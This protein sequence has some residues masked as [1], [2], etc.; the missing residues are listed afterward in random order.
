MTTTLE[1]V[2]D[3]Y[4][5]AEFMQDEELTKAL[6]FIAKL[7]FKPDIPLD[8]ARVEIVRMQAIA[9]KMQMKATFMANV[10]KSNRAKKNQYFT[11]AAEIDKVV[12]ALKFI[13]K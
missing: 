8:V 4:E 3:L 6:E 7:M 1:Q 12:A 13:L 9:A 2:N 5:I 10:D 11:A